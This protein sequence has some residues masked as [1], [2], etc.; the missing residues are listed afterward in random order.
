MGIS[1]NFY[2]GYHARVFHPDRE[3]QV[4]YSRKHC[5][6]VSCPQYVRTIDSKF[7]PDCGTTSMES[8]TIKTGTAYGG[9]PDE[10]MAENIDRLQCFDHDDG[11][12]SLLIPN[13][14]ADLA[15]F[16]PITRE[17]RDGGNI[18]VP[19]LGPLAEGFDEFRETYAK[20]LKL[21]DNANLKYTIEYGA[22]KYYY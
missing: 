4:S 10:F 22:V 5:S 12:S 7:C 20:L 11:E 21:L 2:V 8:Q 13:L 9:L 6:N 1:E 3:E 19:V 14:Y 18:S 15:R 16:S 17:F